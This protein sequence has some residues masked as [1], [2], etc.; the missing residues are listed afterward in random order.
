MNQWTM[1]RFGQCKATRHIKEVISNTPVGVV[2]WCEKFRASRLH[3]TTTWCFALK[4]LRTIIVRKIVSI[5]SELPVSSKVLAAS[6]AELTIRQTHWMDRCPNKTIKYWSKNH[7]TFLWPCRLPHADCQSDIIWL[8]MWI[9]IDMSTTET[10]S[11][12]GISW[13]REEWQTVRHPDSQTVKKIDHNWTLGDWEYQ[14]LTL[15]LN[16]PQHEWGTTKLVVRN[17]KYFS[18][19][20]AV[21]STSRPWVKIRVTP[22]LTQPLRETIFQK[23]PLVETRSRCHGPFLITE[24]SASPTLAR[25]DQTQLRLPASSAPSEMSH[26]FCLFSARNISDTFEFVASLHAVTS[27]WSDARKRGHWRKLTWW[28]VE[29]S[30][31]GWVVMWWWPNKKFSLKIC[32][33]H[34]SRSPCNHHNGVWQLNRNFMWEE[35]TF[36]DSEVGLWSDKFSWVSMVFNSTSCLFCCKGRCSCFIFYSLSHCTGL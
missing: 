20:T 31:D 36:T 16:I 34:P 18:I 28:S 21:L 9:G 14:I 4:G 17:R 5:A 1:K 3:C 7:S 6:K 33:H 11:T 19:L 25:P 32:H 24:N 2:R 35:M 12:T 29:T 30:C 26:W 10:L 27:F 13:V 22:E 23:F 15:I 8:S